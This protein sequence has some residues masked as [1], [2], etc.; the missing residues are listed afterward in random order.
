MFRQLSHRRASAA[1]IADIPALA[2]VIDRFRGGARSVGDEATR[3]G[4]EAARLGNN[5]LRRLSDE[6]EHRP[7]MI[8]A[9]AA[10]I[11]FLAGLSQRRH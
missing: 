6:V 4:Q 7:L 11:G 5:A 9:V 3:V 2:E 10:G 1:D 8:L